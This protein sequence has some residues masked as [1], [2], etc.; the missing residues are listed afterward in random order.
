MRLPGGR[1]IER[2]WQRSELFQLYMRG[3]RDGAGSKPMRKD[4]MDCPEYDKAYAAGCKAREAVSRRVA[5]R[6]RHTPNILRLAEK[7]KNGAR[8]R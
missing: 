7:E 6:L 2:P 8:Q 1:V 5:N 3:W 4:H